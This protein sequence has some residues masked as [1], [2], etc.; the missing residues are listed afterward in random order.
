MTTTMALGIDLGDKTSHA[1]LVDDVGVPVLRERIR[2][3]PDAMRAFF[4]PFAAATNKPV[5]VMES[6]THSRW[7]SELV[8]ELGLEVVVAN[9]SHVRLIYGSKTKTDRFDAEALARLARVDVTLLHP[10]T[11]RSR[12]AQADLVLL[13]TRDAIVRTRKVLIS[14][15]RSVVKASGHRLPDA[16]ADGFARKVADLLPDELRP[17]LVHALAV[18]EAMT[19]QLKLVERAIERVA[20]VSYPETKRLTQVPGIGPITSL[21]F[22]LSIEDPQRFSDARD[23]GA[24]LGLVPRKDQS[25]GRD[26]HLRITKAGNSF[27]RRLLVNCA[28]YIAG[29]FGPDSNLRRFAER[30]GPRGTPRR[31]KAIVAVARKL[32]VL[33][34]TLWRSGAEYHP[35]HGVA[36]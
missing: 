33:L 13:Q 2:T 30:M 27:L 15:M 16:D 1:C 8:T 17:A 24:W 29:P 26:P 4:A 18:I 5:V 36:A 20:A 31:K 10:V 12:Q 3:S 9:P 19:T 25:G 22:V 28:Q 6:G 35:L 14:H 34:L 11:H 7:V 21:A 32:S 23:V